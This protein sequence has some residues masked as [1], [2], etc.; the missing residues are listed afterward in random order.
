[1][2]SISYIPP[3]VPST[4][5]DLQA[6]TDVGNTTTNSVVSA[7]GTG[8]LAQ[9]R[10]N[11]SGA[12]VQAAILG[13]VIT[14]LIADNATGTGYWQTDYPGQG[15]AMVTFGGNNILALNSIYDL[16]DNGLSNIIAFL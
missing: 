10:A 5:P 4:V 15:S 7:D 11:I 1:M 12:Q 8:V 14:G 9:I 2:S 16:R 6:V 13:Q 3:A